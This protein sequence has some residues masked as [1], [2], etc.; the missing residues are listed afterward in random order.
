[1]SV[2]VRTYDVRLWV[3]DDLSLAAVFAFFDD[4]R[5]LAERHDGIDVRWFTG[6]CDRHGNP[7]VRIHPPPRFDG[8]TP[9]AA[10]EA[11]GKGMP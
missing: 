4:V 8:D 11:A 10:A 3:D 7:R 6:R 1:V 2:P 9:D 5:E